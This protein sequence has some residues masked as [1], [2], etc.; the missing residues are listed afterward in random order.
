MDLFK[1]IKTEVPICDEFKSI[2]EDP[3]YQPAHKVLQGWGEGLLER[4]GEQRKF[5]IEFQTTFNSSFGNC[6]LTKYSWNWDIQ[7][8]I[9][10]TDL[11][12]A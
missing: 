6:I 1:V 2:L 10:R 9:Q 7:S 3:Y 5:V 12:S 8:I 4:G 11:I